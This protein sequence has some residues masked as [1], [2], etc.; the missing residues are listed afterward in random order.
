[1]GASSYRE[2]KSRKR[3]DQREKTP[4]EE[5]IDRMKA[6]EQSRKALASAREGVVDAEHQLMEAEE[7]LRRSEEEVKAQIS[8]LDPETQAML[9][10][11]LGRLDGKNR[12]DRE[13]DDDR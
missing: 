4:M 12:R 7:E 3:K 2:P 9:R 10:G 13:R 11:M 8:K 1:M 6:V 5:M